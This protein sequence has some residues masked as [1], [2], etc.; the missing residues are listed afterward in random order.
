MSR[1]EVEN[2]IAEHLIAIRDIVERYPE[3]SDRIVNISVAKDAVSAFQYKGDGYDE[4]TINFW[5]NI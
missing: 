2:A 5:R 1:A 4:F 3:A